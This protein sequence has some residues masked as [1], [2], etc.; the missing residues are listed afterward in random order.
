VLGG[1]HFLA[2]VPPPLLERLAARSQTCRYAGGEIVLRQGDPGQELF[3]VESGEVAVLVGRAGGSTAEVARLGAGKFFGEMSLM[4]GERRS[5]TVQAIDDATL[6]RVDKE[7]FH[8][9]L[10]ASPGLAEQ[11]TRI[12]V[13]RQIEIEANL[14][15]RSVRLRA[16][17]EERSLALLD[18]IRQFFAL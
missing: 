18:R 4:T 9:I 5:A 16:E 12:L 1:V 7:A 14:S 3:I 6:V 13:E 8:D 11:I 17:T 10:A 15:S 2:A